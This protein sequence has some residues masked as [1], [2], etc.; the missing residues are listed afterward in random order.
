MKNVKFCRKTHKFLPK[1][2]LFVPFHFLSFKWKR[3]QPTIKYVENE[4]SN[5]TSYTHTH[6]H[7]HKRREAK[8]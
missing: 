6:T 7:T 2:C 4:I 8:T 1:R 5:S 3:V